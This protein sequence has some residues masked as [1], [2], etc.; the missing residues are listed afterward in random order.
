MGWAAGSELYGKVIE[1][2]Q[3]HVPDSGVRREIHVDLIRAFES[4]DWD[5]QS[6][7]VGVDAA[8]DAA[9]EEVHPDW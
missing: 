2:L 3:E 6:E 5:T 9:L 4:G 1:A 8:F 7:C